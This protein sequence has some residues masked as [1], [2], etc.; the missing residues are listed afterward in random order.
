MFRKSVWIPILIVLLTV[1]GGGLFYSSRVG[2]QEPAKVYKPVEVK[3]PATP[4]PP[5]PGRQLKADTGMATNGTRYHK[6]NPRFHRSSP[7][8]RKTRKFSQ[9]PRDSK[10]YTS[11]KKSARHCR[12]LRPL[13]TS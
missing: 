6:S 5:P 4:K 7:H 11:L 8:K 1:I 13:V 10:D 9:A 12:N 2:K 3:N